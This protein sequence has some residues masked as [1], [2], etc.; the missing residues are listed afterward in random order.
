M[1]QLAE[2][3][4]YKVAERAHCAQMAAAGRG[5]D[6]LHESLSRMGIDLSKG[7]MQ[8]TAI[9]GVQIRNVS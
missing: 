3:R 5:G 4:R 8:L 2:A 7:K 1:N 6:V 9:H